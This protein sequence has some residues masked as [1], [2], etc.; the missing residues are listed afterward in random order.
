MKRFYVPIFAAVIL[1]FGALAQEAGTE[2]FASL[3]AN[4]DGMI[5]QEEAQADQDLLAEF[6]V[7]DSNADGAVSQE[8][9][10]I[11]MADTGTEPQNQ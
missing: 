6:N 2:E 5:S 11:A 4:G 10:Q 9:Y 7:I 1:P 8:E 3:D